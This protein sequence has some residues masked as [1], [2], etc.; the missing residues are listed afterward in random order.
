MLDAKLPEPE[1]PEEDVLMKAVTG[2]S[3]L[4]DQLH[5]FEAA[6]NLVYLTRADAAKQMS[7][8]EAV[9]GPLMSSLGNGLQRP[10][11]PQAI[12]QVHHNLMALGNFAKGFPH[13]TDSQ[14]ETLPYTPAFK[15]MTEAL[16][17][18][19]DAMKSQRIVRDSARFAFSQFV[20]AIGSTIAELVPRFVSVV[21][22]EFET[23]EL[24]DFMMFL[25]LLMHRLKVSS[26]GW[27]GT[28][29]NGRT[30]RS[31]RS[32]CCF[33]HSSPAFSPCSTRPSQ[34]QTRRTR[35]AG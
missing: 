20:S 3:Y 32:T 31:K 19:L 34:V 27:A 22:T 5:L 15:Q 18:A 4:T 24:V 33:F 28:C 35:I 13:V 25:G 10:T 23:T 8:L 6:G 21:V 17:E 11:E 12:L 7:L 16:L 9:A 14:I 1:S 30:T 26:S 29:A 2:T